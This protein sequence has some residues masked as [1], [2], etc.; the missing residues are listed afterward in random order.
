MAYRRSPL[1]EERLADNRDRIVQATRQLIA[2]GGFRVAPIAAVAAAAGLSTGA[3]YRYFPSKAALF[4]DV[5]NAAVSYEV[6]I[7][8]VIAQ[9]PEDAATRLRLAVESFS[10]RALEGPYLA[11]AFIVEPIDAEVDAARIEGRRAFSG[12]FRLIIEDGIGRGEFPAQNSDIA[13]ACIVGAF[14][15]ALTGPT[16]PSAAVVGDPQALI[17]SIA[18]FC[19]CAVRGA[20]AATA[21][22]AAAQGKPRRGR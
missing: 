18:A 19:V 5:L 6:E 22:A 4:V 20:R 14:T 1:M 12:V 15:E 13:A 2:R 21:P 9:G 10:R 8:R 3:I 16:A 11:Y 17:D 7:L